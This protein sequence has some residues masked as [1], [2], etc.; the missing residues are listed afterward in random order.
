MSTKKI[1]ALDGTKKKPS[2]RVGSQPVF[3]S[4]L[5]L[6]PKTKSKL[7]KITV[8][9]RAGKLHEFSLS[10]KKPEHLIQQISLFILD[11]QIVSHWAAL[12][13][14]GCVVQTKDQERLQA[15]VDSA[16][17]RGVEIAIAQAAV[18][19]WSTQQSVIPEPIVL[20]PVD[21]IRYQLKGKDETT[22]KIKV[23]K[24]LGLYAW[25]GFLRQ[26][27]DKPD[28]EKAADRRV[29]FWD[30]IVSMEDKIWFNELDEESKQAVADE[31]AGWLEN[32][33]DVYKNSGVDRFPFA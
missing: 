33:L 10:T 12:V 14:S 7:V 1:E 15:L 9:D 26:D 11:K 29:A 13:W 28:V 2:R 16:E 30:T 8:K 19:I 31:W 18:A 5:D 21:N 3:V 24:T 20:K 27:V 32:N 23:L 25:P 4:S 17:G 22:K 6:S